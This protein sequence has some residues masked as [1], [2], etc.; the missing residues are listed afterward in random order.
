MLDKYDAFS[1]LVRFDPDSEKQTRIVMVAAKLQRA[2][3]NYAA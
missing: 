3:F 1:L 2:G